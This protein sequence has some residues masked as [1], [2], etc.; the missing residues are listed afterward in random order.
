MMLVRTQHGWLTLE[1]LIGAMLLAL[2]L[3]TL[4]QSVY[5]VSNINHQ[6]NAMV[7]THQA[8]RLANER[9][10]YEVRY[11]RTLEVME[12]NHLQLTKNDGEKVRIHL[13]GMTNPKTLYLVIDRTQATPPGGE[14]VCPLTEDIVT[15][16]KIIPQPSRENPC[17]IYF[18]LILWQP[19]MPHSITLKSSA[20]MMAR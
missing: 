17:G 9:I 16:W 20:A 8:A 18:E 14:A 11:A 12:N 19:G 7:R 4:T 10:L 15:G 6:R 3:S 13:G 2:L 1:L 5:G